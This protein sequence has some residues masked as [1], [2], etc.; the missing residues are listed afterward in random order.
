MVSFP[1]LSRFFLELGVIQRLIGA[2]VDGQQF[3]MRAFLNNP[4]IVNDDDFVSV[5]NGRQ[6]MGDNKDGTV[7]HQVVN[8]FLN[9]GF[10]L[11]VQCGSRLVQNDNRRIFDKSAGNGQTLADNSAPLSPIS[12]ST[13]FSRP[14]TKSS[15][16]AILSAAEI[17]SSDAFSLPNV[18]LS[19]MVPSN[20]K[21]S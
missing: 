8:G 2:I 6:A 9:H 20:R 1:F 10:R 17:S 3:L 12:V 11:V 21:L 14:A 19:R 15:R 7:L 5:L 18:I 16:Y 4:A 13:P